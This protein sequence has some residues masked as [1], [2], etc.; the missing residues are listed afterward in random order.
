MQTLG[1][2]RQAAGYSRLELM[3][4]SVLP[5]LVGEPQTSSENRR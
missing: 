4:N 5:R 1:S 3:L 2:D